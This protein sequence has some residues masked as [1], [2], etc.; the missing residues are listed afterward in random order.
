MN[1]ARTRHDPLNGSPLKANMKS[2]RSP[3]ST[4]K[5]LLALLMFAATEVFAAGTVTFV[6]G[7]ATIVDAKGDTR[8][9]A[10]KMRIDTGDTVITGKKGEVHIVMD[11][12]GLIAMR[13]DSRMRIDDFVANGDE[14]DRVAYTL[15]KGFMRSVT[16]WIG[17]VAPQN[18]KVRTANATVGIRGTDHEV[19]VIDNDEG[20]GATAGTYSK[21]TEGE[22]T[23]SNPGGEVRV[24]AGRAAMVESGKPA[25]PRL[26]D[27]IPPIFKPTDNEK[28]IEAAKQKLA[29]DVDEKL[30][31]RRNEIKRSGGI[32]GNGNTR[33]NESC[34]AGG[35]PL[36]ELLEFI[37]AYESGN[38]AMLQ[39]KL[40]PSMLG[41]Q[42]FMDGVIQDMN[43]QKQIRLFIKDTLVQCGPDLATVQFTWEKRYLDVV[44]FAPGFLSGRG[45]TLMHRGGNGWR[46]AG[47]AGDN[48][49]SS[50]SGARGQ[51][52]FGPAFSLA[53]VSA[54]PTNVPVTV[55]VIDSDLAGLGSLT[56]QIISSLGDAET[57]VL[58]ETSS[59]RFA[60]NSLTIASG[61][62]AQGNGILEVANGVQL[63]LRYVDQNPGNNLPPTMLTK[64]LTPTGSILFLPDTTPDPF[65]FAPTANAVASS[66]TISNS[67]TITGINAPSTITI[68]G[69]EYAIGSGAFTTVGGNITNGQQV[70]VRVNAS[71]I[72]GGIA[73]ATLNIGGV[74]SVFTVTT[75]A[76]TISNSAPNPFSFNSIVNV[77]TNQ[78]FTSSP[79]TISGINVATP[80]AIIGAGSYSINGGPFIT[81]GGSV[82]NGQTVAVQLVSSSANLTTTSATLT[83]GGVTGTFSVTTAPAGGVVGISTP[84]PFSYTAQTNVAP[85]TQIDSLPAATI[86][87]INVAS[88]VTVVGGLYSINSGAF[89]S[90]SGSITNGQ[91]LAIRVLSSAGSGLTTSATVN[92]G[93]ITATFSVTTAPAGGVVGISTPNPFSYTAQTNVAP[94]TQI[95]SLP[96]A[97]ISGINVASPVTVVG[98]LYSINSGAFTSAS[99]SITNGQTLAI[100]VLSSAGSGLTT[101][102]TVNVGGISATF[103]VT[104]VRLISTPNPFAFTPQT[105]VAPRTVITSNTTLI[106]GINTP[107]PVSIIG[108]TYSINGGAFT[109]AAG[110]ILNNQTIAVQVASAL[111]TDGTGN[112]SASLNVGGVLASFNVTTW[113][114]TPNPFAFATLVTSRVGVPSCVVVASQYTTAAVVISGLTTATSA[115]VSAQGTN[116]GATMLING[117]A[118]AGSTAPISN[119][120]TLAVRVNTVVTN[121]GATPVTRAIVSIGGVSASVT[122]T[123]Q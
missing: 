89:T 117:V 102:A 10:E 109:G 70:R 29:M 31:Q 13:P 78:I 95:D 122:Q 15:L 71:A 84:N 35:A 114:T 103:S 51:L 68:V 65:S 34:I 33:L 20:K 18:Y 46:I 42:R 37:R 66:S 97:T 120:Q 82:T 67:V 83:I 4:L 121:T 72:G 6:S 48:P 57:I 14:K 25:A 26:L 74:Q 12:R 87:G 8:A 45:I 100:R 104:T 98:G 91:T 77:A 108:G 94:S 86:S 21:V 64:V 44:T 88:P 5:P 80:V 7:P 3:R 123:C 30:Q 101:S 112:A 79:A 60:R 36:E 2:N 107:A 110:T 96:A 54:I 93:G 23:L 111:A 32:D 41:Y 53:A 56:V 63:T 28:T 59:G 115:S 49:F 99:G 58:P 76:A 19:G 1:F 61:A 69:G 118:V 11:D 40:D 43:R 50:A 52:R 92:V 39:N 47:F 116:P 27:R 16:G 81:A 17:K 75:A 113:D 38:P 9:L 106:T 105:N 90:A 24:K 119:G 22:T 85:S 55:E 73:V 62:I